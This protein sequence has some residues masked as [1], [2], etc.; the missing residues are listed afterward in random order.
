MKEAEKEGFLSS[1]E[2]E[3]ENTVLSSKIARLQHR[4]GVGRKPS[5]SAST[6]SNITIPSLSQSQTN[7]VYCL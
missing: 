2:E 6:L 1:S 5:R 3:E 7:E 4:A